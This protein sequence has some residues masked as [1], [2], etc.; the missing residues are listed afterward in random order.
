ME[1]LTIVIA[2]DE[3]PARNRLSDLIADIPNVTL[4]GQANNGQEA[5]ALCNQHQPDILLLDIRMPVMDGVE[6]AQH[7]QKMDSKPSIIFTTAYD[8]YAIRAFDLNAIDYVLKPIR[9]ERLETA[10]E[11]V[12]ALQPAQMEALKPLENERKH[13]SVSERGKVELVPIDKI[14]FFKADQ[15]Y[16]T[17]HTAERE[18]LIEESLNQLEEDLGDKVVRLHRNSLVAKDFIK[19]FQ[20]R[21]VITEDGESDESKTEWVAL[22]HGTHE[23]VT[24][25]RRQQ[26]L[27]KQF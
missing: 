10:I 18:Y 19:G 2:D 8:T 25:S 21:N 16:V 14:I 27:I 1:P 3:A 15:K 22:L 24:V 13:I 7:I 12:Q 6:A 20:K 11:K 26:H 9:Q 4:I 5:I 23:V 17:I